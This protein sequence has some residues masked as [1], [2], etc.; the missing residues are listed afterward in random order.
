MKVAISY[1]LYLICFYLLNASYVDFVTM[2][3][4]NCNMQQNCINVQHLY[5][6]CMQYINVIQNIFKIQNF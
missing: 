5:F 3:E 2:Q 1:K 4:N 6:D